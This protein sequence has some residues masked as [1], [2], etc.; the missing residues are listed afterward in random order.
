MLKIA[1]G[2]ADFAEI[3]LNGYFYQDRTQFIELLEEKGTHYPAFLRPRRF[4]KSLFISMLLLWR[5]I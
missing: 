1:Y 3:R 2:K 4:G 5:G